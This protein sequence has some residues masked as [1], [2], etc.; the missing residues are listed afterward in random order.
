[1]AQLTR[2]IHVSERD[3]L[4]R[5]VNPTL[6]TEPRDAGDTF[7]HHQADKLAINPGLGRGICWT[8]LLAGEEAA[9]I[10]QTCNKRK[11]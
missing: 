1:M 2:D 4:D 8:P 9:N 6:Q 5:L 3:L 11:P 10:Q 7:F